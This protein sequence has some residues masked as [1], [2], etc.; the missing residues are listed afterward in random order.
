[1]T[2]WTT[3]DAVMIVLVAVLVGGIYGLLLIW[4]V[5]GWC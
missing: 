5:G 2:D 3:R 1:M 4:Y